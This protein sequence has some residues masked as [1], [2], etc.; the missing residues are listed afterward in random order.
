MRIQILTTEA[1][2]A[3]ADALARAGRHD[4][5]HEAWYHALAERHGGGRAE[6]LVAECD[7]GTLAVPLLFRKIEADLE[8]ATSVYG[9]A[10]PVGPADPELVQACNT[11]L[12]ARGTVSLFSRLHPLLD[13]TALDPA[14]VV[15]SGT[16]TSIDLTGTPAAIWSGTRSGHRNGINRLRREGFTC[17]RRGMAGLDTFVAVYEATIPRAARWSC[18]SSS[19]PRAPLRRSACSRCGVASRSTTC[20]ARPTSTDTAHR[21]R[22]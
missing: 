7:R 18:S 5:H 2:T 11:H 14:D 17:E 1:R 22:C 13:Q 20:R 6:L 3:W 8:D 4:F 21:P 15:E 19:I 12:R 9:Y 10:G 16:T